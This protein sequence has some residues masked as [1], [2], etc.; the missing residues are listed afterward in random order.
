MGGLGSLLGALGPNF[1]MFIIFLSISGASWD[2]P[3]LENHRFSLVKPRFF[4]KLHFSSGAAVGL[5]FCF[6]GRALGT[7][8]G[9]SWPLLGCPWVTF[10]ASLGL[11]EPHFSAR[12][13]PRCFIFRMFLDCP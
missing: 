9:S 12:L 5:A 3:T 10:F 7:L 1:A 11:S 4:R 13:G 8:L 2:A 6:P